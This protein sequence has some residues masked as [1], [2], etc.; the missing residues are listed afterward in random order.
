[1]TYQMNVAELNKKISRLE[2]HTAKW[3][4]MVQE[5]AVG[6]AFQAFTHKNVDSATKLIH[7][8]KGADIN[9]VKTWL[10]RYSPCRWN[11]EL[12]GFKFNKSFS[13]E[14]DHA[15]LSANLWYELAKKPAQLSSVYDVLEVVRD[16]VK[17]A[18]KE[19]QLGKKTVQHADMI[20]DLK[21]LAGK[22]A[23][24]DIPEDG[25][26]VIEVDTDEEVVA[27]IEQVQKLQKKF[28]KAA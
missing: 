13:G 2:K 26:I 7:S 25:K 17:R 11:K 3:R 1:M 28:S 5:V 4:D 27:T 15:F 22:V 14:F 23:Q 24:R 6:C 8:L 16:L 21:A 12:S 10:E 9:A 19:I 18:E 20:E